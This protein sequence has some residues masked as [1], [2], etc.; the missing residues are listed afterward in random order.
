MVMLRI[1]M[2]ANF[3]KFEEKVLKQWRASQAFEK[4]VERRKNGPRFVFYEGP[5]TANGKPGIHHV[6]ARSFKDIVLRYKTMRG[7]FVERRGGWD[8]HGLPVELQVEKR[9]GLQSKRDIEKYGIAKFNKECKKSVWMYLQEWESLTDRIGF[10]IDLEKS[11]ITYEPSYMESLWA[12]IKKFWEKGLLYKDYKVVPYCPRCGTALSSHELAQ[13][14]KTVKDPAV[15]VKFQIRKEDLPK[16]STTNC[17][18]PAASILA[19]TTTPWTL[20]SNIALAVKEDIEYSLVKAGEEYYILATDR[21]KA[22]FGEKFESVKTF[23]GKDLLGIRYAPLYEFDKAEA[24]KKIWEVIPADFVTTEDGT[25]VVHT[26]VAYGVDDFELGKK[27]NLAMFHL[28]SEEGKFIE[29]VGKFAGKF[30]KEADPL[31]IEDLRTRNLLLREELYEHE[32]PFCWRCSTPLLYYAKESWFLDMQKVKARLISNNKK[33]NWVPEYIKHGRFG[34]WLEDVKDWAFSRERY[35]GTPL[36]VWQCDTCKHQ[37]VIGSLPDIMAN[38]KPKN[39]YYILRHGHSLRQKNNIVASWPEKTEIPLTPTGKAEAKKAAKLLKRKK[40]DLIVSSDLQ[41][42]RETAEI[43]AKELGVDVVYE[44]GLREF[45]GGIFNGRPVEELGEYFRVEGETPMEHFLRRFEKRSPKGENWVDVQ[46]RMLKVVEDLEEKY[47]GKNILLVGHELPFTML[48]GLMRGFSREEVISYR[49]KKMIK[50]G[51][52]RPLSIAFL[53]HNDEMQIDLHRPY[54]DAVKFGCA[55]CLVS[56]D[57]AKRD[58]NGTMRRVKDVVDVWFDSGAMPFAQAHWPFDSAQDKPFDS[59]KQSTPRPSSGQ[60]LR[61]GSGQ[62]L[63]LGSGQALRLGSGQ[64]ISS[65]QLVTPDRFPADYIVEGID[66]TRGW[67]YTL[68]AVSTLLG[69][70]N[71]YKNVISLGHVLDEKGE[72]MSKSKGNVVNPWDMIAKYGADA[73][74][75]Y[76]FTLNSPGDPKLFAEKDLQ[77]VH[78]KFLMTLWNSYVFYAT[79]AVENSKTKNQKPKNTTKHALDTWILSRLNTVA[80]EMTKRMDA[81]DITGAGRILENFVI[82]DVSL[83]YIRRSRG[84][85]QNPSSDGELENASRTLQTVLMNACILAAPFMPFLSEYI[86]G[87]IVGKSWTASKKNESVHWQDWPASAGKMT[88]KKLEKDMEL[89]RETVTKALAERARAGIKVRQPLSKLT[90]NKEKYHLPKELQA[91]LREEINVKEVAKGALEGDLELD[92]VITPELRAEGTVR[93][94]LRSVQDMRKEAGYKPRHRIR[95]Q[96]AGDAG[97][98]ELLSQNQETIKKTAGVV[99]IFKGEKPK[100]VFDIEKEFELDGKKLWIGI[101][102]L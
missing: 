69:F 17:Q 10:W 102:R 89:V 9:L 98:K 52:V 42:T 5:P 44:K 90:L 15:Y 3:P 39:V 73:V 61:L 38:Q 66:Q 11:Y 72:K 18:L 33:I 19:W 74:R 59:S 46:K 84:R 82:N 99:E 29:K 13:G 27:Q 79:Y 68:L 86:F 49:N 45:D 57:P 16:L 97:L 32:Y 28:V 41:R 88:A 95:L 77:Q 30:V 101:K 37:E 53:P 21:V 63:R 92:T 7:F 4:S 48:E 14:Y 96:Y 24:G 31:I 62:A 22:V 8:T 55:K 91:I 71:P 75:W 76:F 36:P 1:N 78:R 47:F 50:T 26:A 35:W 23:K 56:T 25:G 83:W 6:L 58:G 80:G 20:P 12:I 94:I 67:F 51:E 87:E 70:S 93:E 65:K 64:A 81:Y 60:A 85:L 43:V 100:Q 2:E 34:G 40:I 54:I